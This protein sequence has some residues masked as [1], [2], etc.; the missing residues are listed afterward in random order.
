[1]KR[2]AFF[3]ACAALLLAGCI[4]GGSSVTLSTYSSGSGSNPGGSPGGGPG[5]GPGGH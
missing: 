2:F 1:M 4:S 3:L 5:G